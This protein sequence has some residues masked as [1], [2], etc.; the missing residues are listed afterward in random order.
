MFMLKKMLEAISKNQMIGPDLLHDDFIFVDD[1]SM[2]TKEEWLAT[3]QKLMDDGMDF[4]QLKIGETVETNDM[5]C[6]EFLN[7]I[8]NVD[9]RITN[10]CLIKDNK[11]WRHIINRCSV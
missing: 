4:S 1:F 3:T 7:T 6:F 11:I 9:M 10:V 2:E 8:E 5:I